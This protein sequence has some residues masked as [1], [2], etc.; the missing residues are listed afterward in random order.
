M[1]GREGAYYSSVPDGYRNDVWIEL[2]GFDNTEPD[3]G[4][5]ELLARMGFR[6]HRVLLL[7]TSVDFVNLHRADE[8]DYE[9]DPYFC[10]YEGH[11]RCDDRS[12]QRWTKRQLKGL[13]QALHHVGVEVYPS[14]FDMTSPNHSFAHEHPELYTVKYVDGATPIVAP[15]IYMTKRFADGSLYEDYL[16]Q[17]LVEVLADYGFD[18]AH[19]A[20]GICRPRDPLQNA[21]YS[22]DMLEQAGITVPAEECPA[23]YVLQHHRRLWQ[24]FCTQR[25]SSFLRKV[26][27][28]IHNAGFKVITNSCWT[29]DPM[30]ALYRYGLDYRVLD[31]LAIDGCVVENGAP[32]IALLDNESAAG[33]RQTYADRQMVHH[34]F[35]SSLMCVRAQLRR[36]S[37]QPLFP[38]RDTNEQY[39]VIHHMPTALSRHAAATFASYI[40]RA[41]GTLAP[42][43]DGHTYCLSD[44]LSRDNW[45]YLRL[46]ADNGYIPRHQE[47]CGATLI[48]SGARCEREVEALMA[49]R[50]PHTSAWHAA[51]LRNG[52]SVYKI[53]HIDDL[54]VVR[55]DIV[56]PNV[57]LMPLWEQEAIRAY[58]AGRVFC[59][60]MPTDGTDYSHLPNPNGPTFTYP[61]FLQPF[62][63]AMLTRVAAQINERLPYISAY[64]DACHVQEIKLDEHRSRLIVDNEE[65]Y[66]T[67]PLIHTGRRIESVQ[68]ITHSCG[69]KAAVN[70]DAVQ[71]LVPLRG[72]AILEVTFA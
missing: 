39:D 8:D 65:F 12:L 62:D 60:S 48:W 42:V 27:G 56:V 34:T 54:A 49:H 21:D 23:T 70:G 25:W 35:R 5:E 2:I 53:A 7:L 22:P 13:I 58:T 47:V 14:F 64:A 10:S 72:V 61:L 69:Y 19:L 11:P 44:G 66:Y 57:E 67:R 9:L 20:D 26:I 29:K 46:C 52:A 33:F 43:V 18:G 63:V 16:L 30:E 37:L 32:T 36:L 3:F 71:V 28:G 59:L 15:Y 68:V 41:D 4:V 45:R 1:Y 40:W 31:A 55:G 51:L 50:T 6:P 17:K 38:V 24:T